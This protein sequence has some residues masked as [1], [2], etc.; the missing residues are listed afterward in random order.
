ML[1]RNLRPTSAPSPRTSNL[2]RWTMPAP[3]AAACTT[4]AALD[5]AD[6]TRDD[7]YAWGYALRREWPD[8]THDLFGLTPTADTAQR[9]LDRDRGHWR[10]GPV[11]P[12]AVYVGAANAADVKQHPVQGCRHSGCPNS[13]DRGQQR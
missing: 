4:A 7:A 13:P 8:G 10:N 12:T 3:P 1:T 6:G 11:Q 2:R 9:R 5:A